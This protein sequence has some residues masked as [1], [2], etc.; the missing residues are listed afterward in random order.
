MTRR[1]HLTSRLVLAAALAVMV[2]GIV[3]LAVAA[4]RPVSSG[5]FAYAPLSGTTFTAAGVHV[6][7]TASLVGA[8]VVVV[9]LL[10]LA[11]WLGYRQGARRRS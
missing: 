5:W 8:G 7:S 3:I 4:S 11:G 1:D 10:L 9:G 6:L 2:V